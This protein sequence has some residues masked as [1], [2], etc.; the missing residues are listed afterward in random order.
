VIHLLV[1]SYKKLLERQDADQAAPLADDWK[2]PGSI[3]PEQRPGI[4]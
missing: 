4:Y 2:G 3:C 1:D